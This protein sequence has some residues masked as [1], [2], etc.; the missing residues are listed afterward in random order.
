MYGSFDEGRQEIGPTVKRTKTEQ[1]QQETLREE[2]RKW[3]SR[4]PENMQHIYS[5]RF[6]MKFKNIFFW[7]RSP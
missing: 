1:Q 3:E 7:Q 5:H 6:W 2:Q 4:K